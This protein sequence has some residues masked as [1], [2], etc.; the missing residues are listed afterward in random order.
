M[1]YGTGLWLLFKAPVW[2]R[3]RCWRKTI[4]TA[5]VAFGD[6]GMVEVGEGCCFPRRA[7]PV[8]SRNVLIPNG[9]IQST[10]FEFRSGELESGRDEAA[11][12]LALRR[13][14]SGPKPPDSQSGFSGWW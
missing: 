2:R 14:L 12:I 13:K 5:A 4:C 3:E 7:L 11:L 1:G 10:T 8:N 9:Q 6:R